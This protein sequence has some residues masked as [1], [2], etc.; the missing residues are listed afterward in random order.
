[1][2]LSCIK[3]V[4]CSITILFWLVRPSLLLRILL[5]LLALP[6]PL[7]LKERID[8]LALDLWVWGGPGL[9]SIFCLVSSCAMIKPH[10]TK[11]AVTILSPASR[12]RCF[13]AWSLSLITFDLKRPIM[14]FVF[15]FNLPTL[16]ISISKSLA[17][18]LVRLIRIRNDLNILFKVV[19]TLRG[20]WFL[21]KLDHFIL[22]SKKILDK[23]NDLTLFMLTRWVDFLFI[24][25]IVWRAKLFS[26]KT[27]VT[28]LELI[29]LS[30]H[31]DLGWLTSS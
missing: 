16:P 22:R 15:V 18:N 17:L 10:I 4:S 26:V 21:K 20:K 25:L 29:E 1:M 3:C 12:L 2:S 31:H 8:K 13:V 23:R 19:F 28:L 27:L 11:V 14:R 7:Q 30:F 5:S 9:I 6:R 24:H